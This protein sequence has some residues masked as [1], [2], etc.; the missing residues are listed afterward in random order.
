MLSE[1]KKHTTEGNIFSSKIPTYLTLERRDSVV[2]GFSDDGTGLLK[3]DVS[4]PD[5]ELEAGDYVTFYSSLYGLSQAKVLLWF[6]S[7][8]VV[9]YAFRGDDIS[10]KWINYKQEW[11]VETKFYDDFTQPS[12]DPYHLFDDYFNSYSDMEG[13]V[14]VDVTAPSELLKLRETPYGY[15]YKNRSVRYRLEYRETWKTTNGSWENPSDNTVCMVVLSSVQIYGNMVFLEEEFGELQA[16]DTQPTYSTFIYNTQ[17]N[18]TFFVS[19]VV[20]SYSITRALIEE[21]VFDL[22]NNPAGV[23]TFKCNTSLLDP[24]TAF[25]ELSL[26]E[27]TIPVGERDYDFDRSEFDEVEFDTNLQNL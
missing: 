12:L 3:I 26:R 19:V 25:F 5:G 4:I 14:K 13:N 27:E 16:T 17:P 2:S 20:K 23:Y 11:R 10:D 7:Y 15:Q 9:D 6:A 24:N 8:I 1:I 18:T 22:A 21:T